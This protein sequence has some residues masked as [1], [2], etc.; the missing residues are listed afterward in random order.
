M[1]KKRYLVY[2]GIFLLVSFNYIDRVA[3]SVAAP[4]LARDFG[5][6]AVL[7]GYLFSSYSWTYTVCLIPW[8]FLTDRFGSR[9]IN[10]V[11]VAI[12]SG[13]TV[14]TGGMWSYAS[15]LTTRLVMGAAEASSYPAGGRAL[16]EWAP[17]SEYGL[18]ATMLNS[19]G[20][21]GPVLGLLLVSWVVSI[22]NWRLGF[23]V[24]GLVGLV[25][26]AGWYLWYRSPE[27]ATFLDE[28]ER[29]FILR[30]R[31]VARPTQDGGC[32]FRGLLGSTSM[33]AIAVSQGCSVY[34]QILFLTW[35]PSYLAT[36][37]HLSIMNTGLFTALPYFIAVFT[38]WWLAH[39]S[40]RLLRGA[41]TSTGT[42]RWMVCVAMLS[43][44][45]VLLAPLVDSVFVILLLITISLTGLSTGISLNIALA[46]DLLQS[47]ADAGK[48]MGI[49]ITGGNIFGICA[50]IVTGY[51]IAYTGS[52]N[53]AFIVGGMLLLCG[54]AITMTLTYS[55]IGAPRGAPTATPT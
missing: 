1:S 15:I 3:L 22:S 12:W 21:L 42:R 39:M 14:L 44:A 32:G 52:Y 49:Q 2:L 48:A 25:W 50:P 19:G 7:L 5:L 35:L 47:P 18:A 37:K 4:A 24:A 11:G 17:R 10:T 28:P 51:I 9:R 26:L 20:Y 54:A 8:G 33:R 16:R 38:S 45:V 13:A 53:W 6:S 29:Q 46:T 41:D 40:D 36:Q 27:E 23:V 30:E 43:A 34:T 31:D 55:P